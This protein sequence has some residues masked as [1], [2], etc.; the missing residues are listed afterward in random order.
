MAK[1][2]GKKGGERGAW[3]GAFCF[4]Q[5]EAEQQEGTGGG[6]TDGEGFRSADTVCL[7]PWEDGRMRCRWRRIQARPRWDRVGGQGLF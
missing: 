5:E 3:R 2:G 4:D 1:K 6:D 7:V